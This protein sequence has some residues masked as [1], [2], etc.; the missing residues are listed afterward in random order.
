MPTISR[1]GTRIANST[2]NIF[3]AVDM[4]NPSF[5]GFDLSYNNRYTSHMGELIP[6]FY[7]NVMPGDRFSYTLNATV[8]A[9]PTV[10]PIF[11]NLEYCAEAFFVPYSDLDKKWK[12]FYTQKSQ[13]GQAVPT[14]PLRVGPTPN[15]SCNSYATTY[16]SLLEY[17]GY[18]VPCS[19]VP[20]S[21][22]AS[23][24]ISSKG[25]NACAYPLLA[26]WRIIADW[27]Q[28]FNVDNIENDSYHGYSLMFP[29]NDGINDSAS[30]WGDGST[31]WSQRCL[32]ASSG[33]TSKAPWYPFIRRYDKDFAST[34]T[35]TKYSGSSTPSIGSNVDSLR[36]ALVMQRFLVANNV[37]GNR[38]SDIIEGHFGVKPDPNVDGRAVFLG[39]TRVPI[40]SNVVEQTSSTTTTPLGTMSGNFY[41]QGSES[42]FDKT[43]TQPG[44]IMVL[45]SINCPPSY[46]GFKRRE[47]QY[48]TYD[49]FGFPEFAMLGDEEVYPQDVYNTF[50]T[51]RGYITDSAFG[52]PTEKVTSIPFG[53]NER[54]WDFKSSR[55][56]VHG[57]FADPG[58]SLF[59]YTAVRP[60]L[61]G[62][63]TREG[64]YCGLTCTD[65]EYQAQRYAEYEARLFA[66]STVRPWRVSVHNS[67]HAIRALPVHSVPTL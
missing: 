7:K 1:G 34:A 6:V 55:D 58:S 40:S 47:L 21:D 25:V 30:S 18:G 16:G 20:S 43:F 44:I 64:A 27:Y 57:D 63:Y 59:K 14:S 51:S 12:S 65:T 50:G 35:P 19:D 56:E 62:T 32:N 10:A 36:S 9:D 29:I 54:Y 11:D 53:Y 45:G 22:T 42:M 52:D 15:N 26:Y 33:T 38:Y 17:L 2:N 23:L 49:E 37:T 39:A 4:P 61:S 67:C 48:D 28:N 60:V 13:H 24:E 5:S 41:A 31:G 46:F 8:T 66:T 3:N